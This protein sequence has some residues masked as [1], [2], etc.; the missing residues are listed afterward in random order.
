MIRFAL[1]VLVFPL[2]ASAQ[3]D[4]RFLESCASMLT[5]NR[6]APTQF[7]FSTK[8]EQARQD[9]IATT[10]PNYRFRALNYVWQ[11]NYE[12]AAY[13]FEKTAEQFPKE[14]G[15]VGEFYFT[16]L[17]DTTR[18]LHHLNAF[19]ALTPNFD[20]HINHSPVSYLRGL[21]YRYGGSHQKAIGQFCVAID[22]L[23]KKR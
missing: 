10:G 12:Q 18:A 9:T 1:L 6:A 17:R 8:R 14:H 3:D 21:V 23:E 5:V 4:R 13:W 22:S 2:L 15:A 19:D 11:H 16:F 7:F 20:D